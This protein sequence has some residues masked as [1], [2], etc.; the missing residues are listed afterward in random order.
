MKTPEERDRELERHLVRLAVEWPFWATINF[1]LQKEF[2]NLG[3]SAGGVTNGQRII[4]DIEFWDEHPEFRNFL[5][6]H[7]DAHVLL[8]HPLIARAIEQS[9]P[10]GYRHDIA[11]E[12]ADIAVNNLLAISGVGL[13]PGSYFD[14]S[15]EDWAFEEIYFDL[16]KKRNDPDEGYNDPGPQCVPAQGMGAP[17]P[18]DVPGSQQDSIPNNLGALELAPEDAA[19]Q[20]ELREIVEQAIQHASMV[21]GGVPSGLERHLKDRKADAIDW[22]SILS[23]RLFASGVTEYTWRRPN[24]AL[25]QEDILIPGTRDDNVADIVCMVDTS[26]SISEDDL[27]RVTDYLKQLRCTFPSITV[28]VL[29]HDEEVYDDAIVL[30]PMSDPDI[31]IKLKGGG[32]TKMTKAVKHLENKYADAKVIVWVTDGEIFDLHTETCSCPRCEGTRWERYV[33]LV[34][35]P[36]ASNIRRCMPRAKTCRL[37]PSVS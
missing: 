6:L 12:A 1:L 7:E 32:G 16:L 23:E 20:Q 9:N 29:S 21:A 25:L 8:Q 26:G 27:A 13:P 22:R 37:N 3:P 35:T 33:F 34:T 14:S 30:S 36:A 18:I 15:Y 31:H 4:Y 24:R 11:Q 17:T 19:S 28:H 5:T 10:S 2:G